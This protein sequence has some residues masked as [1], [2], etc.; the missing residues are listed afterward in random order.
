MACENYAYENYA[1]LNIPITVITGTQAN[2][3]MADIHLWQKETKSIVDF[4]RMPGEHFF[5]F[6][7][8]LEIVEIISKKLSV[9]TRPVNY[10]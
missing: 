1:P 3:E 9:H 7:Y 5:I 6:K 10:G 2:M 8:P 4:R